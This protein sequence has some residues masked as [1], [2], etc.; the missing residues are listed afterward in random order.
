[1]TYAIATICQDCLDVADGTADLERIARLYGEEATD[2]SMIETFQRIA[3][4]VQAHREL[5]T[6]GDE[7]RLMSECAACYGIDMSGQA[8]FLTEDV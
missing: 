4:T 6:Q 7:T 5:Y 3:D 2:Q 8:E 1:M